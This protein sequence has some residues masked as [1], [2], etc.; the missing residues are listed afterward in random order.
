MP[1]IEGGRARAAA[2]QWQGTVATTRGCRGMGRGVHRSCVA[3]HTTQSNLRRVHLFHS[4]LFDD[5]A[6]TRFQVLQRETGENMATAGL[7]LLALPSGSGL[8]IEPAGQPV[9]TDL[10]NAC[11]RIEAFRSSLP[12]AV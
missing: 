4:D 2:E 10:R 12:A 5:L 7:D 1:P 8:R 6:G 9:V 11:E 3:V